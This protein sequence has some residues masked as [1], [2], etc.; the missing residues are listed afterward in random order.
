MRERGL[1]FIRTVLLAVVL[2]CGCICTTAF[3]ADTAYVRNQTITIDGTPVIFQTYALID[4]NGGETN[5]VK[6]RDVA[7]ALNGTSAPFNVTWDGAVN[8]IPNTAY[9][10]NGSEMSTPFSGDRSYT[11]ATAPTKVNGVVTDLDAIYL[12]DNNGGGYTY[13]KLRDLGTALGF[14]VDWNAE[15]GII[16]ET[17]HAQFYQNHPNIISV[18]SIASDIQYWSDSSWDQNMIDLLGYQLHTYW[19]TTPSLEKAES[20][21]IAYRDLLI[22]NGY[23]FIIEQDD[24]IIAQAYGSDMEYYL[25]TPDYAQLITFKADYSDNSIKVSIRN[26]DE[27]TSKGTMYA[28]HPNVPDFGSISGKTPIR[29]VEPTYE[30]KAVGCSVRYAAQLVVNGFKFESSYY[31][32]EGT[33]FIY[34]KGDIVIG[35]GQQTQN[36]QTYFLVTIIN[37]NSSQTIAPISTV[38]Q[39]KNL[40]SNAVQ[41]EQDA[42]YMCQAAMTASSAY[43]GEYYAERAQEYYAKI[44]IDIYDALEL[45]KG[46]DN[47]SDLVV[48]L[49]TIYAFNSYSA[50]YSITSQNYLSYVVETSTYASEITTYYE[51]I[52][53]ILTSVVATY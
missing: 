17:P 14:I 34:S 1:T 21:C 11:I 27:Y 48:P 53:E 28:N 24:P 39:V 52:I 30:Y 2:A 10:A 37:A 31:A 12:T 4:A 44:E 6:V 23:I 3:A 41:N 40:I 13:Y 46:Y 32:M 8:L 35:F 47:L 7:Y 18:E 33:Q 51:E 38:S 9:S 49:T 20:Y 43:Y 5:Y 42:L 29:V 15:Q 16:V 36:E 50:L 45:C 25:F 22:D 19:Y 26:S